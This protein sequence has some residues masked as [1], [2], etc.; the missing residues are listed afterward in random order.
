MKTKIL[1]DRQLCVITSQKELQFSTFSCKD[2][3][4]RKNLRDIYKK[5]AEKFGFSTSPHRLSVELFPFINNGCMIIYTL[6]KKRYKKISPVFF[7]RFETPDNL[8]DCK[9]KI[10][11]LLKY[12]RS[13]ELFA[14]DTAYF[15]KIHAKSK[16]SAIKAFLSEYST[17][18]CCQKIAFYQE[19]TDKI[20]DE[21]FT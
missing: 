13:T 16:I 4:S 14:S 8:L 12:I 19:Y 17:D 2:Q 20:C 6:R 7:A 18:K 3:I 9:L 1:N 11:P 15:V 21:I 5:T 10:K